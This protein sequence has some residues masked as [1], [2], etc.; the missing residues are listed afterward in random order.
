MADK[1]VRSAQSPAV[2]KMGA[3]C[4]VLA[5]GSSVTTGSP[6]ANAFGL[7]LARK[8][9]EALPSIEKIYRET[10]PSFDG[11]VRTLLAWAYVEN[12]RA[13][14]AQKLVALYPIP[15]TAGDPLFASLIFPRFLFLRGAALQ[16]EPSYELYL[17]YVGD[18]PDVFGEDVVARKN[19]GAGGK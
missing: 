13:A 19:L 17:K 15:L 7:M 1:A 5:E 8:Y 6:V 18:V 9:A 16:S 3:M 2:Q 4:R 10:N 14:D 11:Q 12:G